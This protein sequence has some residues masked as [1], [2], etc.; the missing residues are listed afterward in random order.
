MVKNLSANSG[1]MRSGFDLW[2]ESPDFGAPPKIMSLIV[3]IVSPPICHTEI[4]YET[5]KISCGTSK[6]Q[7]SEK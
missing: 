7:H 6:T 2:V 4:L 3:Y 5:T 1:D